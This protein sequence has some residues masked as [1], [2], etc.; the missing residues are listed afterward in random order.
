MSLTK[1]PFQSKVRKLANDLMYNYDLKT[2]REKNQAKNVSPNDRW[3]FCN[4]FPLCHILNMSDCVPLWSMACKKMNNVS[5]RTEEYQLEVRGM[6][7][8]NLK[9]NKAFKEQV[10]TVFLLNLILKRHYN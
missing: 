5:K 1:Q 8:L 9:Q 4:S 10:E 7:Y 6:L 3:K 2:L